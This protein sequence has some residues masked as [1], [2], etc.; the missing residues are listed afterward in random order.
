M[1]TA[2]ALPQVSV[3]E[4]L[5]TEYEPRCEY[6]DGVLVPK[7]V[8]DDT[9]SELQT[10]LLL[11][12][13]SQS[14]VYGIKARPELHMRVTPDTWRIPDVS[15]LLLKPADGRYPDSTTLPLFTIEIVSPGESWTSLR[16]KLADH[17]AMGVS[18]VIIADPYDKT[19][20]VAT[21]AEPLHEIR[22]PLVVHIPVPGAG[23]LT[24]DFDDL[25]RQ[26]GQ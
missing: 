26:L 13:A 1:A 23:V 21:Q 16:G 5:R 6:L 14:K 19:V 25:Y 18:T 2:P 15:G 11:L 8:A 3:E 20:M 7:A 4:Y 12:I 22:T 17:L 10:L 24:I 9:H